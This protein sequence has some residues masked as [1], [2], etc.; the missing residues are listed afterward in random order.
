MPTLVTRPSRRP[1]NRGRSLKIF[2]A[3]VGALLVHL[4]LGLAVLWVVPHWPRGRLRARSKPIELTMVSPTAP[5]PEPAAGP[6]ASGAPTPPYIRTLDDQLADKPPDDPSFISDKDTKAA[7]LLAANGNKPLPATEGRD[8]PNF[9]FETRPYRPGTQAADAATSAPT[10][11]A[12]PVAQVATPPPTPPPVNQKPPLPVKN[13]PTRKP[14]TQPTPSDA[15]D[16]ATLKAEASPSPEPPVPTPVETPKDQEDSAAP[17]PRQGRQA[18]TNT[19]A[20]S[21]VTSNGAPKPPGYQQQSAATKMTGSINN[22][23]RPAVSAIGTPLGRYQ[24]AVHDQIGMLWYSFSESPGAEVSS[25]VVKIHFY[26]TRDGVAKNVK[27]TGGNPNGA[28]GL[29]SERAIT[30]ADIPPMPPDVAS[31]LVGGQLEDEIS[32]EFY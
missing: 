17:P 8:V 29:V 11:E 6:A 21:T 20:P 22:R 32:F 5:T 3:L 26:I 4:L 28:L 30:E 25:G 7:S 1:P 13:R 9:E 15:G 27:F 31:M 23:G 10:A 12:T 18:Q 24:K 2:L 14:A 19:T 16:L